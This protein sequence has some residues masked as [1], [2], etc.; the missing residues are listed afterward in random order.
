M[1]ELRPFIDLRR[2]NRHFPFG[3]S[4]PAAWTTDFGWG[5]VIPPPAGGRGLGG[6]PARHQR[7]FATAKSLFGNARKIAFRGGTSPLPHP[8]THMIVPL[9]GRVG[10][11]AGAAVRR[12]AHFQTDSKPEAPPDQVRG[13]AHP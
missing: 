9:G 7:C 6:G 4:W 11:R 5:A 2:S 12:K 10:E 3:I 13:R 1:A 8:A